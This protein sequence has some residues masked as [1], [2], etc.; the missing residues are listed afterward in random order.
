[1]KVRPEAGG[2]RSVVGRPFS[3]GGKGRLKGVSFCFVVRGGRRGLWVRCGF[4]EEW[5]VGG[6]GR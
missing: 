2:A 3:V 4:Y 5:A 6:F 1:M